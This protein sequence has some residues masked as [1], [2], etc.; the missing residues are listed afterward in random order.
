MIDSMHGALVDLAHVRIDGWAPL[1]L[2]IAAVVAIVSWIVCR[3][4]RVVGVVAVAMTI[5]ACVA[6][7]NA[8][9]L[10]YPTA[11]AALGHPPATLPAAGK[12]IEADIPGVVSGFRARPASIYL[13]PA[14][15]VDTHAPLPVLVLLTGQPGHV[16]DWLQGGHLARTMD[17]YAAAHDGLAPVVVVADGLGDTEANPMC[18]DSD[19]GNAFTYLSVDVPAWAKSHL[20]VSE[21]PHSWAIGGYSYGG[22]CA[23]Q[24]AVLAPTVYPTF[25][26]ISGEDEPR[27]GTRAESVTAAFGDDSEAS[28]KR[29]DAVAPLEVMA[30]REFPSTAGAFLAGSEDGEFRPQVLRAYDRAVASGMDA[31]YR[32]L[33]GGHSMDVWAPA[34]EVEVDWLSSRM[35]L[36]D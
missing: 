12:V 5:A 25:L 9:V 13:P 35:G 6:Q 29:F 27:R 15:S 31:H 20:Q 36:T 21:D 34:L 17:T 32:E 18:M 3:R 33:P 19:L 14:Y 28:E 11:A 8:N 7:L 26:D 22:T 23:L 10:G 1:M 16:V 4:R 2:T 30:K 24:A